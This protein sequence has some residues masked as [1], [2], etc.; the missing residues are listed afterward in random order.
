MRA[1][2]LLLLGALFAPSVASAVTLQDLIRL[3]NAGVADEVL[4]AM[5]ERDQPVSALEPD[6]VVALKQ[7]GVSE[8]VILAMIRSSG[9]QAAA[10]LL[11]P[12]PL[13]VV[14]GHGPDRPNTTHQFERPA[15]PLQPFAA[16]Y[17]VSVPALPAPCIATGGESP[18]APWPPLGDLG[19]RYLGS[20]V[21][22]MTRSGVTPR[23]VV[24]PVQAGIATDCD[25]MAASRRPAAFGR[26]A[27]R[28]RR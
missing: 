22:R 8:A 16:G 13:L 9:E 14:V 26:R 17:L 25:G 20:G 23:L 1:A 10:V 12:P 3:S 15:A 11:P 7:A 6:Q 18:V 4:I 27:I 24:P 21:G 2:L 19:T 5:I 28:S